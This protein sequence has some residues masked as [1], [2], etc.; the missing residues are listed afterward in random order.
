MHPA[1]RGRG[2]GL[3]GVL[4]AIVFME[5]EWAHSIR[6]VCEHNKVAFFFKQHGGRTPKAGGDYLGEKQY[7][8]FPDSYLKVLNASYKTHADV[9][10]AVIAGNITARSGAAFKAGITRKANI[11]PVAVHRKTNAQV[12]K[13]VKP[14]TRTTTDP[15]TILNRIEAIYSDNMDHQHDLHGYIVELAVHGRKSG[16]FNPMYIALDRLSALLRR[17][18]TGARVC[19]VG[20]LHTRLRR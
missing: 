11:I 14:T 6:K 18:G 1:H 13:T 2:F 4:R 12:N 20:E 17:N 8:Q 3:G 5:P 19:L 7:H 16:N 10:A 9:D 15:M